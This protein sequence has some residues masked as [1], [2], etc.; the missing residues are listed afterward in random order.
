[1]GLRETVQLLVACGAD[2][3]G[4]NAMQRTPL[5]LA[6]MKPHR[7]RKEGGLGQSVPCSVCVCVCVCAAYAG[8]SGKHKAPQVWRDEGQGAG[9][10][11]HICFHVHARQSRWQ[12]WSLLGKEQGEQD[13][14]F[15]AASLIC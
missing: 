1:M 3:D 7:W 9:R 10:A 15:K 2:I 4:R 12:P 8:P 11:L 5:I 6:A 14:V 13:F